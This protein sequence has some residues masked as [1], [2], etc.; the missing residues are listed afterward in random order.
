MGVPIM[1]QE[2]NTTQF[3]KKEASFREREK[4][5]Q[6]SLRKYETIIKEFEG[7]FAE[8]DLKGTITFANDAGCRIWG[9][10]QEEAAGSSSPA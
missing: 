8:V 4:S 3:E 9:H 5:L 1:N 6:D 7:A 10:T 2:L